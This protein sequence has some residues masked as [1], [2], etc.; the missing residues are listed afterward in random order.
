MRLARPAAIGLLVFLEITALAG[1]VPMI[2]HP[3]GGA[4]M[5]PSLLEHSPFHSFL[6]PG[7]V[8]LIAN[9][10]LP[11][12][13]VGLVVARMPEH[14]MWVFLQGSVLLGWLFV[15]CWMLHAVMWLHWLYA[16]VALAMMLAGVGLRHS[17]SLRVE[18]QKTR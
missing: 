2:L 10:V 7:I 1:A 4:A 8:L 9:G 17:S 14:G 13:V 3:G 12:V 6:I 16:A 11:L 18:G 5:P 15:E